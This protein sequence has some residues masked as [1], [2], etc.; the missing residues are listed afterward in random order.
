MY[1][2]VEKGNT[3]IDN[4][5]NKNKFN[6]SKIDFSKMKI[7]LIISGV[8]LLILLVVKLKGNTN[9][10]IS[11]EGPETISIYQNDEYVEPGYA[12][13]DNK[14]NDLTSSVS[15]ESNVDSSKIGT[16]QIVYKLKKTTKTRTVNVV[17]KGPAVT[18]L[19]LSGEINGMIVPVGTIYIEPGYTAIDS[20][21]NDLTSSVKV[22]NNIDTSTPGVYRIIYSVTN[23]AGV[24][25]TKTRTVIVK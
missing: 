20:I 18:V 22:T 21:D 24:T 12:G 4:Q 10:F 9:Y 23:S 17:E 15:I 7:P 2:N 6:F 25:I 19:H 16:Y 3:N 5:F 1:L 14:N 8:V 13:R 11:L